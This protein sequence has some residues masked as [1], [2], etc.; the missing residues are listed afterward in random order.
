MILNFVFYK[1]G[2]FF[3]DSGLWHEQR[4]FALRYLRDFG[5]GRRFEALE[6]EIEI[7]IN[8]CIDIIKNG[9]KYPHERVRIMN[10]SI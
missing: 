6:K 3:T 7:Q 4:R 2:I 9:P 8:Q 1:T 10:N 5:F